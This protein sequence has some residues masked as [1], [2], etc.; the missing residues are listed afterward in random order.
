M[1]V[2]ASSWILRSKYFQ[3]DLP[4][5]FVFNTQR[6]ATFLQCDTCF[7]V[8][9]AKLLQFWASLLRISVKSK[10]LHS[11]ARNFNAQVQLGLTRLAST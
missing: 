11:P 8:L 5:I 3:G 7:Y 9:M 2:V 1:K 6:A 10:L 4:N